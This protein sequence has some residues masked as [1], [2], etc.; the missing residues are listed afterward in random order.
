MP[1]SSTAHELLHAFDWDTLV[2]EGSQGPW[3]LGQQ[4]RLCEGI[5]PC[6]LSIEG[7][8]S[9]WL[10]GDGGSISCW[11]SRGCTGVS[12]RSVRLVCNG[13]ASPGPVFDVQQSAI[14]IRDA[15][16][17]RCSSRS[18]GGVVRSY[19]GSSVLV[20]HSRFEDLYTSGSGA[21]ISAV[22]GEVNIAGAVFVNCSA[23]E[24]GGA[25]RI[26]TSGD[27]SDAK[28]AEDAQAVLKIDSSVFHS[29]TSAGA[30]GA[31]RAVSQAQ[32]MPATQPTLTVQIMS[33]VFASCA[34]RVGS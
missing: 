25:I 23:R 3:L 32:A 34:A 15:T 21:A 6:R 7:R 26:T 8:G 1:W 18:D 24:G 4:I 5:L 11:S 16:V 9:T 31:V 28:Q 10:R 13:S 27:D 12:V 29:C 30:G 14:T 22:G 19:G 20:E 17:S 2:L 33:S